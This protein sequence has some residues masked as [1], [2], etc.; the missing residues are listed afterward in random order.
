MERTIA[1][2]QEVYENMLERLEKLN[3]L[4]QAGVDSWSGYDY[5]MEILDQY[6]KD[7]ECFE[8]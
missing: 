2:S 6:W 5:A 8:E 4:E 7:Q 3:A 1:I